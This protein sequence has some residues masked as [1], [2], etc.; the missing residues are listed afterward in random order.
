MYFSFSQ[1]LIKY[2]IESAKAASPSTMSYFKDIYTS[3][4]K[5][6]KNHVYINLIHKI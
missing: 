5:H 4:H 3:G 2:L 1:E 6:T